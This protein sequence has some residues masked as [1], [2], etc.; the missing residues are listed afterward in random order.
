MRKAICQEKEEGTIKISD[1]GFI[2]CPKCNRQ[3]KTKI[4]PDTELKRFPLFC[5]WCKKETIISK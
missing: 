5:P 4:N 2:I 1:K 3:T